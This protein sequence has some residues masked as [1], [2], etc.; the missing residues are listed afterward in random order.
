MEQAGDRGHGFVA[1]SFIETEQ[2]RLVASSK[3]D[4]FFRFRLK[5]NALLDEEEE[6]HAKRQSL[7]A[8]V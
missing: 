3:G 1:V 6:A 8:N 5:G 2:A 7:N 4:G